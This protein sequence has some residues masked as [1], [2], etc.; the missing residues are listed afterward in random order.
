[1]YLKKYENL[2]ITGISSFV[3]ICVLGATTGQNGPKIASKNPKIA[4]RPFKHIEP[5][6]I[7]LFQK[8]HDV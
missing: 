1:M 3:F 2:L 7:V 8:P 4:T 5:N 6:V